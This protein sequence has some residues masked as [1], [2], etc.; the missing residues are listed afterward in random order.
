MFLKDI[1][2][3]I[4]LLDRHLTDEGPGSPL[5]LDIETKGN[6]V[7][8]PDSYVV[9]VGFANRSGC[10]YFDLSQREHPSE[11]WYSLLK[12][13]YDRQTPLVGHNILFDAAYCYRDLGLKAQLNWTNCTYLLYRLLSTEGWLGQR[14]GLKHAQKDLLGWT[15]TNEAELNQWLVDHGYQSS[16][17]KEPKT[18]YYP[19]LLHGHR[20]YASPDKSEM[21]RA[22]PSILGHYCALDADSTYQ[23]HTKVLLPARNKF[24]VLVDY[25]KKFLT[26]T[27]SLIEQQLS[28]ILI[29]ET[30]LNLHQQALSISAFSAKSAFLKHPNIKPLVDEWNQRIVKEHL[31]KEPA[32]YR[33]KKAAPKEPNQLKKNGEVSLAWLKWQERYEDWLV[34]KTVS[35][36]WIKWNEKLEQ[37]EGE[38]HFNLGSDRQLQWLFYEKLKYPIILRTKNDNPAVDKRAMKGFREPGQLL[39]RFN[40]YDKEGQYVKACLDHLID[41]KI[42]PHFRSPGTTTGR[43]AGAGG[44]NIQQLPKTKGYLSCWIPRPGKVFVDCDHCLTSDTE[45]LT[46]RGWIPIL[47]VRL[48]DEVWQVDSQTLMG[49]WT[50]P[51]RIIKK[52][53]EG[54]LYSFGNIRGSLHV[55]PEHKMLFIGQQSHQNS[56]VKNQRWITKA[57]E[58]IPTTGSCLPITSLNNQTSE[59]TQEE[60]WTACMLHADGNLY[61]QS[62]LGGHYN[63]ELKK[64]RKIS[65]AIELLEREGETSKR[66]TQTWSGIAFTNNIFDS[67]KQFT[68]QNLGMNQVEEFVEALAFWDGSWDRGSVVWTST[69]EREVDEVQSYL[70]RCGYEAKKFLTDNWGLRI[71]RRTEIRLG[72][73]DVV[74]VEYVGEVG[75]LEVDSGFFQVRRGGQTFITGNC[76]LENVVLTELSRDPS[77][78]KLYGPGQPPN[79]G[80]LFTGAYLPVLGPII[81]E[82]GYDPDHPTSEG[83]RRAKKKAKKERGI[84]K[85][86][87]YASV[88]KAGPPKL[89]QTLTLEGI[90]VSLE[91]VEQMHRAYWNLYAGVKTY[92]KELMR[93]WRLNRGWLLN[94][95]GRPIGVA[96]DYKKD[97]VNRVIQSTGH[98]IHVMW[99]SI[100][101]DLFKKHEIDVRGI[102]WDWHDQSI[103]EVAEEDA[104]LVVDIMENQSYSIL[105]EQLGGIIPLAGDAN[106]CRNLAEAKCE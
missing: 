45:V 55:T 42:H 27:R 8:D 106:I 39:L 99:V 19:I 65:R 5:A 52:N 38:N 71:K 90:D 22:P 49:S 66:N 29:D 102:V 17:S 31:D 79:D 64:K 101:R 59:L 18:N 92:E 4:N 98:D 51:K 21:W 93:Q 104:E 105:N 72:K 6:R 37:V 35:K 60:I 80:H 30:E 88:Y 89:H 44:L 13:M 43:L 74:K 96:E 68:L 95:I 2:E 84:A 103:V 16:I 50:K 20:R 47:E 91:E 25:E 28:G 97:L 87:N 78:M 81:R 36:N 48:T 76:A 12:Y 86:I 14:W 9:G 7:E 73:D 83:I 61:H 1:S 58:G 85:T 34:S 3:V 11:T 23:L 53:H 75:C 41:S 82:A 33:K 40:D 46:K 100:L 63:L 67:S 62:K 26:L 32:Y 94:G 24:P 70:T 10:Y 57:E 77:L 56:N 15:E 69:R 54:E